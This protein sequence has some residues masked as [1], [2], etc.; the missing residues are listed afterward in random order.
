MEDVAIFEPGNLL[1]LQPRFRQTSGIFLHKKGPGISV[2]KLYSEPRKN[3]LSSDPPLMFIK[4]ETVPK[5]DWPKEYL[6]LYY[7]LWDGGLWYYISDPTEDIPAYQVW[8][9][10][11]K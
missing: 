1:N 5:P 2:N 11:I 9:R 4:M 10:A 3:Y 6:I 7:F 8:K